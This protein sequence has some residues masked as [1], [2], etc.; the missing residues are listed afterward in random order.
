MAETMYR[1]NSNDIYS[2]LEFINKKMGRPNISG[3]EMKTLKVRE[4]N[5][6]EMLQEGMEEFKEGG[7]VIRKKTGGRVRGD[8]IAIR[9]KTKGTMR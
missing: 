8:G 6:L 5:L 7:K 4:Q 2:R 9:G 1:P 3:K